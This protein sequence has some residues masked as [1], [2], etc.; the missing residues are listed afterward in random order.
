MIESFT[1]FMRSEELAE[2]DKP[3]TILKSYPDLI[4]LENVHITIEKGAF[5]KLATF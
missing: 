3:I 1:A 4:F 2:Y 5:L